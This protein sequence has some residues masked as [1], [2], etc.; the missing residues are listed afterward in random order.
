MITGIYE[1]AKIMSMIDDDPG[2]YTRDE[3]KEILDKR[4]ADGLMDEADIEDTLQLF[5]FRI[6]FCEDGQVITWMTADDIPEEEIKELIES[7]DVLDYKDGYAALEKSQWKEEDG[8][9]S[10]DTKQEIEIG[11]EEQSPWEELTFDDEGLMN[12]GSGT[13][14]LRKIS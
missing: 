5:N 14:K 13:M 12:Y 3:V 6:E 10:Y 8:V 4:V 1:V 7:G 9:Y 11:E 2:L